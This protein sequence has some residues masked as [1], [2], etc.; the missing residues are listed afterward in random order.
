MEIPVAKILGAIMIIGLRVAGLMVFAP[1]FSNV[2]IP[3]RI[4][5]ILVI[6]ITAVLYPVFAS[7]IDSVDISK[8]PIIVC[9]ETVLGIA[10]GVATF[11]VFEAVMVAG[12]MLS[13]QMGYSLVNILDPN[14]QVE[15]TVIAFFH[16]SMALLIFLS[17][18][19]HHWIL[20]GIARSFEYLPPGTVTLNPR[21][22]QAVLH[23]GAV[24]LSLGVQIAAPVLGAT[25][26]L[27]LILGL[28][29]KS[30]PQ[31]PLML[32]GPAV[33]SMLGVFILTVTIGYWPRVFD[34]YFG[35]SISYMEQ[36]LHLAH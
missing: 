28:L 29:G 19:V 24:I 31:M 4:K 5:I 13:I 9:S 17:L 6:A 18:N 22:A 10:I 33:K 20:R 1:F 27:D 36:M 14:T 21:L 12:Q 32:L 34:K 26:L 11:A 30:S 8:W 7:R 25:L 15:S 3:P 23:E 35:Q 2:V 16:Q